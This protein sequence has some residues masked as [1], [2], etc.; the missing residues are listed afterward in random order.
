VTAVLNLG[1]QCFDLQVEGTFGRVF[2]MRLFRCVYWD[3]TDWLRGNCQYSVRFIEEF[4]SC[5]Q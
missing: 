5:I 1:P 2:F 4:I 3:A